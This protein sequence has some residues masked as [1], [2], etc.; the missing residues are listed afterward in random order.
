[1]GHDGERG[2]RL[3]R[4]GKLDGRGKARPQRGDLTLDDL[5]VIDVQRRAEADGQLAGVETGEPR[6]PED[7]VAGRRSPAPWRVVERQAHR[8]A[9]S[10]ATR[11][12]VPA[13]RSLHEQGRGDRQA[14]ASR[15]LA[16][17][18]AGPGDHDGP[19]RHDQGLGRGAL[20]DPAADQ[21]VQA[22]CPGQRDPGADDG[23]GPDEDALE[24]RA[25]GTDE[26]VVLDDDRPGAGRLEHATDRHA[27]RQMDPGS[28]LGTGPDQHVGIDHRAVAD[29]RADVHVRRR[30]HDDVL[31]EVD[32]PADRRA[33]GDDPPRAAREVLARR[34]CGPVAERQR[35]GRPIAGRPV[36][37]A[38]EDGRLDLRANAPARRRRWIGFG[39]PDVPGFEV[40]EDGVGVDRGGRSRRP[41]DG[42]GV[43]TKRRG[44]ATAS[45]VRV[46][47]WI[48]PPAASTRPRSRRVAAIAALPSG[49]SGRS[50]A[51]TASLSSRPMSTSAALTGTG[52]GPPRKLPRKSGSA[53]FVDPAGRVPVAGARRRTQG[54]QLS[55]DLVR[56]HGDH[57]V[58]TEGEHRKRPGVVAGEHR[59]VTWPVAADARDL[60]EIAARLLDGDDPG[61]R[62]EAQERVGVDVRAR[63]RR[64][65]V[66]D[67]RQV[68]LVRDGPEVRLQHPGVGAVVVRARRRA[69]HR[70]RARRR[71]GVARIV[72]AVSFVPVPATT[73]T[74]P[75]EG[76]SPA[77]STVAEI[78][79]SRLLDREGGGLAG[80]SAR[81]E[82]V[83]AGHD[84]PPDEPPECR[85]VEGAVG[86]ERGDERGEG[87]GEERPGP[88][89]RSAG[90]RRI[91]SLDRRH[92]SVPFGRSVIGWVDLECSS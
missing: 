4:I 73:L 67:D 2:I 37:E 76:R 90:G 50:G 13:S 92:R 61:M 81:D 10:S 14:V 11:A 23:P 35:P 80:R 7:L 86:S 71:G 54:D 40:V 74:R 68:A 52:F 82:P 65:V 38:R 51:R 78:S 34:D 47:A 88:A 9:S 32:A 3:D 30:H 39:G 56:R 57:A 6:A 69:R 42:L 70:P 24:Q 77:I 66:D 8:R 84:L 19:Q 55:R 33:A 45:R 87:A 22:R 17:E 49:S 27:G 48:R 1:M 31:T 5:E 12:D 25:T 29:E 41:A 44:H 64:H 72:D 59:D 75:R 16:V 91:G 46:R 43:E 26:C 89:L 83:D 36:G 79:R 18:G 60:F 85:L 62:R 21:V 28:D 15:E 53:A 20:D 63:S 58:A